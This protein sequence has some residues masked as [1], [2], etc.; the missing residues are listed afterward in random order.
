MKEKPTK[1]KQP[2]TTIT[3][4]IFSTVSNFHFNVN[5]ILFI[6]HMIVIVKYRDSENELNKS[7]L[8]YETAELIRNENNQPIK[9]HTVSNR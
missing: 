1:V 8:E 4:K 7:K 3:E 6:I 2:T 9:S 5:G